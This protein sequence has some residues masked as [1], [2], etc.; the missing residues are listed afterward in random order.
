M[1]FDHVLA[2]RAKPNG[3]LGSAPSTSPLA[4]TMARARACSYDGSFDF[5]AVV[6]ELPDGRWVPAT[7]IVGGGRELE[8]LL[9]HVREHAGTER[10]DIA[11]TWLCG[12]H[13]W[14]LAAPAVAALLL[15]ARVPDL[16]ADNVSLQIPPGA[17]L[18]ADV[19]FST[20]RCAALAI[21]AAVGHPDLTAVATLDDLLARLR[22]G[23]EAH[24]APL[25]DALNR[26]TRRPRSALWGAAGD[27]LAFAFLYAGEAIGDRRRAWSIGERCLTAGSPLDVPAGFRVLEHA[28]RAEV[29]RVRRS[30][31]LAWRTG[32]GT[33]CFTCPLTGEAE[34]HTRMGANLH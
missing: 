26:M 21:D 22:E 20:G 27:A 32:N 14:A 7:G 30:C 12:K 18:A 23:L 25:V 9:D 17:Y 3:P 31:C 1:P 28:G 11:A 15:D 13:A 5:G 34:R 6:G 29:T 16:S 24:L 8:R 10:L 19:A 33:A 2:L 4:D